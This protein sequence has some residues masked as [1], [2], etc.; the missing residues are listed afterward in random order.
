MR[1]LV[2]RKLLGAWW[3]ECPTNHEEE[4]EKVK[5]DRKED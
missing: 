2:F 5:E 4:D 1:L 3:Y